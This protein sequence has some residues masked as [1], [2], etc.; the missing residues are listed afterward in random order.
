MVAVSEI[1]GVSIVF[2]DDEWVDVAEIVRQNR[3][4]REYLK[5]DNEDNVEGGDDE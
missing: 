4:L 1:D 2:V 3:R 5:M